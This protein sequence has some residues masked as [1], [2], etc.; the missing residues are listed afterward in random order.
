MEQTEPKRTLG[1][2]YIK[3]VLF[4]LAKAQLY[5]C[6]K[7][8]ALAFKYSDNLLKRLH[9]DIPLELAHLNLPLDYISIQQNASINDSYPS[10]IH[11]GSDDINKVGRFKQWNNRTKLD[12][13]PDP[14]ANEIN[15]TEGFF[16]KP[17]LQEDDNVTIFVDDVLRSFTMVHKR[18]VKIKD[19]DAYQYELPASTFESAH[20]NPSNARWN[21]WCPNG[22]IYIGVV[23]VSTGCLFVS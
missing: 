7:P 23:Q 9:S 15:G 20:T 14:T 11:T 22:L 1:I 10:I 21:S 18:D 13:W 8:T 6:L 16:F 19:L 4:P 12:V 17:Y 3:N 5:M 2:F